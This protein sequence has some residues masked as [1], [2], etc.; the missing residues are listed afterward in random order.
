MMPRAD[1]SRLPALQLAPA[2]AWLLTRLLLS[3]LDVSRRA[4]GFA[5]FLGAARDSPHGAA[6]Q[7]RTAAANIL[8]VL[9]QQRVNEGSRGAPWTTRGRRALRETRRD[10]PGG[11]RSSTRALL[12]AFDGG[13]G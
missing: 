4:E 13:S 8:C 12:V 10:D 3:Q 11:R 5:D 2:R 1:R 6:V 9:V 7:A